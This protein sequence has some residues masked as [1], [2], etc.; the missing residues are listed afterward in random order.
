MAFVY[1]VTG[2]SG[3]GKT[4]VSQMLSEYLREGGLACVLL[5]GDRLRA[6]LPGRFGH[7][8]EDRRELAGFYGR[9][10]LELSSQ[11]IHVVCAT[12][13]MFSAVRRWNRENIPGYKEIYLRVPLDE[14]RRRDSKGLYARD[15]ERKPHNL[16]GVQIEA[17]LPESPDLIIDNHGDMTAK[18][19]V[20][21]ILLKF[22]PLPVKA[23]LVDA[24]HDRPVRP[25][26]ARDGD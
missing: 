22:P 12:I 21:K 4:T 10:C 23:L 7:S 24:T 20:E 16:V 18:L 5:D 26:S 9:L 13:S 15:E 2:L 3:A 25:A 8:P 19:A 17:E 14:L 11:G 6:I 1:W